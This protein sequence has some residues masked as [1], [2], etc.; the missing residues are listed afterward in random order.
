[1]CDC[2]KLLGEFLGEG[3][4]LLPVLNALLQLIG[5]LLAFF[6][7]QLFPLAEVKLLLSKVLEHEILLSKPLVLFFVLGLASHIL[8]FEVFLD[9]FGLHFLRVCLVH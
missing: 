1:M 5:Q 4:E 3:F 7:A 8:D 9:A 6:L 2:L